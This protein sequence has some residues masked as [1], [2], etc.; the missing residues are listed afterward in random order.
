M[1]PLAPIYSGEADPGATLVIELYNANGVRIAT[2]MVMADAGG[3]WLANFGGAA[4]RDAPSDVRIM[5]VSA[6]YAFGA[7]AGHNLRT[8]YAPAAL[9]P[10]HFLAQ[11][12]DPGL[13]D[14]PAPLLGG[15]DLANPIQLG[16][17][18]YGSEFLPTEGVASGE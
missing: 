1:L 11:S 16:A 10:G 9:N 4:L 2:Q 7:G 6:P 12:S 8:Y 15:L 13:G 17:V 14:E 3:N 5:Q 18:K